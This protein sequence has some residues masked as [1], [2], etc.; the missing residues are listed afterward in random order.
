MD[1]SLDKIASVQCH[2]EYDPPRI[3][4]ILVDATSFQVPKPF[5][6]FIRESAGLP[7]VVCG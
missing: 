7:D 6:D 1:F 4:F 5:Y 2:N 3:V